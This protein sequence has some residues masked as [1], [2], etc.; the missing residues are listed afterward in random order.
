VFLI[1]QIFCFRRAP[2]FAED[3]LGG[4]EGDGEVLKPIERSFWAKYVSIQ[5]GMIF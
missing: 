2:I 5:A 3:A 1:Q 4:E